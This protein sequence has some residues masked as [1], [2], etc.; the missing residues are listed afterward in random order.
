MFRIFFTR[1][2]SCKPSPPRPRRQ[3][4][5]VESLED[6]CLLATFV[7]APGGSDAGPGT[8]AQPFATIQHGLDTAQPGDTVQVR[9][10]TYRQQRITFNH[11]GNDQAGFI[12]L[13]GFP[14][15]RPVL[16]GANGPSGYQVLMQDVSYVRLSGFEIANNRR[17]RDGS[18]VRVLGSGS[19]IEIRN[20]YIHD[21]RGTDAMGITVY[22]TGDVP[23]SDLVIDGN[24]IA[25]CQ[26]AHSEALTLNGNVTDFQVTHNLVQDVNNIGI[27]LIGGE[28]DINPNQALVA[29][30]GLVAGNTVIRA[31]DTGGEG[32]AAGNYVDGGRDI[33][34]EDNV[35]TASNIGI[36]VGAENRGI[37]ASGI[38][39][40]NNLIEFN[41]KAGLAFGGFDRKPGR[42]SNCTFVNNTVVQNDTQ[43]AGFG[44]LW[45]QLADHN[46]ITNNIFVASRNS[47]LIASYG[48]NIAN[49]LDYNLYLT[50]GGSEDVDITWNG[51]ELDTFAK[52]QRR[53]GQDAHGIFADPRFANPA[54][55]FHLAAGSPAINAG[56]GVTG[57]FAPFDFDGRLRP[58]GSAPDLGAFEAA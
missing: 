46:V 47:V 49:Q 20:N 6:R 48:G 7:I 21:I 11:S 14:G 9:A 33:V 27:D 41:Q 42:T 29:R 4:P 17:I 18:G 55:D 43:D 31:R 13:E 45:I 16:T 12:T 52:Y 40:R 36:E 15:E 51:Q 58:Q 34:V 44:Q 50:R 35:V 32:F 2:R 57:A 8:L 54:G 10:G 22:G 23:I 19:H 39:V 53:T 3:R 30:N 5:A 24:V 56:S 25:R 26:P 37:V 1:L 28:R 38:M